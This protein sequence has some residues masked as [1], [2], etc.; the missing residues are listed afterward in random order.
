MSYALID[1]SLLSVCES[2]WQDEKLR[3]EYLEHFFD[4]I[5]SI[6]EEEGMTIA[7]TELM[8]ELMWEPPH[9]L[10]W[11][12]DKTWSQSL[13]PVIYKKLRHNFEY[14]SPSNGNCTIIPKLVVDRA[15][16]YDEFCNMIPEL[17]SSG[18]TPVICLG[19]SNIPSK[20]WF[21]NNGST[22]LSPSPNYIISKD[23]FLKNI[24]IEND[25]WP[26]SSGDELLFRKAVLMKIQRDL[27]NKAVLFN[28]SFSKGFVKKISKVVESR[29]KI[30][31]SVARRLILNSFE[32]SKDPCL[33]DEALEGKKNERRLRVTPRPSSKRIHYEKDNIDIVFTMFFD[34][35]EHDKGL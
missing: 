1:P 16:F 34:A 29:D 7:W 18:Y 10:P 20:T 24:N 12:Q 4:I 31:I 23:C 11:K 27:D 5:S 28:F 30:L 8:D 6:D 14:I 32:T 13:I 3:D 2:T 19:Q 9:R 35:G 21:F 15:D 33:Q 26:A 25:M 22:Q 17:Y